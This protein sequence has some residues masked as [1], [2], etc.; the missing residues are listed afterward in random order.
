[1]IAVE[2]EPDGDGIRFGRVERLDGVSPD[3]EDPNQ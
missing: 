2:A 1:M 3:L